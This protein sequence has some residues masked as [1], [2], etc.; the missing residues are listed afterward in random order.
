MATAK[1]ARGAGAPQQLA[2][3]KAKTR[4]AP[5]DALEDAVHIQAPHGNA[6]AVGGTPTS[7]LA[8][9]ADAVGAAR[10][11]IGARAPRARARASACAPQLPRRPLR[12]RS[13]GKLS[14]PRAPPQPRADDLL[15]IVKEPQDAAARMCGSMM[16]KEY[17]AHEPAHTEHH[18]LRGVARPPPPGERTQ[19]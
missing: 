17:G 13:T 9:L 10:A 5:A 15:H 18:K 6:D 3:L 1:A 19:P 7:P 8:R 11:S 2:P 14:R 12:G 16:S 4:D